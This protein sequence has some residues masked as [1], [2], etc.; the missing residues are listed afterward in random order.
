G[1]PFGAVIVKDGK[2]IAQGA[3]EVTSTNDPTAHAEIVAIRKACKVL[4]SFQLDGC[5]IYTSCEPCPMCM[6]AIYWARPKRVFFAGSRKDAEEVGFDD[7]HIYKELSLPFSSR[8]IPI[9]Q[10]MAEEARKIF[11]EW[12]NDDKKVN[13]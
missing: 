3:N 12:M 6:G 10:I 8:K 1:G 9:K 5:E 4:G 7:S 11:E 2:I 13:Y